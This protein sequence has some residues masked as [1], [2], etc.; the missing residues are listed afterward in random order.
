MGINP[1]PTLAQVA[2]IPYK[3]RSTLA[4]VASIPYKSRSTL[5]Q[6]AYIPYK[7]RSTLVQVASIPYKSLSS[8]FRNL[9]NI[10]SR[11]S[12]HANKQQLKRTNQNLNYFIR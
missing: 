10:I 11:T 9:N 1:T 8:N 2:S 4:Q 12:I 7:S 5:A 6:V 3:S